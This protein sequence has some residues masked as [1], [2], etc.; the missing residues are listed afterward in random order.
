MQAVGGT[1]PVAAMFTVCK[2]SVS[3][4]LVLLVMLT[5]SCSANL[6][7]AYNICVG[8]YDDVSESARNAHCFNCIYK[9]NNGLIVTNADMKK[10]NCQCTLGADLC[11]GNDNYCDYCDSCAEA[12]EL[13]LEIGYTS[14]GP[15]VTAI[16]ERQDAC[17]TCTA[18]GDCP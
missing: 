10:A 13:A 2:S 15:T 3:A 6:E 16:D 17:D 9:A 14:S 7:N 11:S 1:V 18:D 8:D 12:R 5:P 4:L